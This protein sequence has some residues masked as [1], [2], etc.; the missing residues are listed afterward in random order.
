[1]ISEKQ[2]NQSVPAYKSVIVVVPPERIWDKESDAPDGC[3]DRRDNDGDGWV[4][5]ND[6]DYPPTFRLHPDP[7][8]HVF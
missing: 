1:L 6:K 7:S 8:E 4:D 5:V 3:G 2:W